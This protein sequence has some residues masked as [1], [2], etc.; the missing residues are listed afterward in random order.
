MTIHHVFANKSN[1]GDWLSV[2]GIQQLLAPLEVEEHFC[3][4]SF[5]PETLARL[6]EATP[7]DLIVIGVGGLFMD[8]FA[9][10]WTGLRD[11][12]PRS[13]MCIWGVGYCDLKA[14]ASHPPLDV[15]LEVVRACRIRVV[16]DALT[17][18]YLG[19]DCAVDVAPCPS[20]VAVE[21]SPGGWGVL[22]VDNYTTVGAPAF[23]TMDA[24]CR[25][26]AAATGRPYRR[27]NSRI[28]R[29][30]ELER[31]LSLYAASDVVVSSALHGCIIP[32]AM[33]KA[34]CAVSGDR[35]IEA[36]M[37]AAGFGEWV[38][39]ATEVEALP[40]LLPGLPQQQPVPKFVTSVRAQNGL[41]AE[42]VR[43]LASKRTG[44]E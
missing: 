4:A 14:D 24:V 44:R 18:S 27:T 32:V 11:L 25:D 13:A 29:D 39:D 3:D 26:F 15:V 31:V 17:R 30:A 10:F 20:L 9:P 19:A 40:R 34:V 42:R 8:Y 21:P 36:F 28:D 7:E 33:G 35:K 41:I 23:D 1:I 16:R 37:D 12:A 6:A 22:H 5:V 38:L 43:M 2:R